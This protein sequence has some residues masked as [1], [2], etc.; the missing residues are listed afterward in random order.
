MR[1]L[2]VEDDDTLAVALINVLRTQYHTVDRAS[3]GE[4]GW[5]LVQADPYD[6]IVLDV[7]LP[8]MDGVSLCQRLRDQGYQRPILLL[9]ARNT[10]ADCTKGLDAGADDYVVKPFEW[11]ELLARIRALLRRDS[12]L[13]PTVLQWGNLCLNPASCEVTYGDR[14]L[15]LRPKEYSL[16]E[17]FLRNPRRVFSCNAIVKQLWSYE[18]TPNEETVRA[19]VKGLRQRLKAAGAVDVLETVYGLGYRLREREGVSITSEMGSSGELE[20]TSRPNLQEALVDLWATMKP[21]VLQKVDAVETFL[22]ALQQ[23]QWTEDQRQ[24]AVLEVHRIAGLVGTFGLVQATQLARQIEGWLSKGAST[25][26]LDQWQDRLVALRG[27]L[28]AGCPAS[29]LEATFSTST[30]STPLHK[31]FETPAE[32]LPIEIFLSPNTVGW[33]QS[34]W[35]L[36]V[37]LITDDLELLTLVQSVLKPQYVHLVHLQSWQLLWRTLEVVVPDALLIDLEAPGG[38]PGMDGAKLCELIYRDARWGKQ[39]ILFLTAYPERLV[40]QTLLA[41]GADD[42]VSRAAIASELTVRI[43]SRV[44]Q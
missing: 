26:H 6:L 32:T 1:I 36:T 31:G 27:E 42:F 20:P 29:H 17:L 15:S 12:L 14:P 23:G 10:L 18:D 35:T 41:S 22:V 24:Q 43:Q 7:M 19:H 34:R 21:N 30:R 38:Y 39:P 2:L 28:D 4:E 25:R 13:L 11:A 8:K 5:E 40:G 16:L 3:D 44:K 9:T 33:E 37:F